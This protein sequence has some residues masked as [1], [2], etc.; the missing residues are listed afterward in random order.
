MALVY[1]QHIE[2]NL[3]RLLSYLQLRLKFNLY[4]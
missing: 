1:Y 3:A 2:I 4:K